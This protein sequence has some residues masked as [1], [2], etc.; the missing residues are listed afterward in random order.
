[1]YPAPPVTITVLIGPAPSPDDP[2]ELLDER[3]RE[4]MEG[5]MRWE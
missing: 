2:F 4:R 3:A 5:G 1:M